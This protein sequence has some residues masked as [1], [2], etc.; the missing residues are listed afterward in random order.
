[1]PVYIKTEKKIGKNTFRK[2]W[3]KMT[4]KK[5]LKKKDLSKLVKLYHFLHLIKGLVRQ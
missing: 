4:E 2:K 3:E 5:K 1:M